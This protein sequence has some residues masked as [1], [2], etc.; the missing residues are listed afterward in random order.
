MMKMVRKKTDK[1]KKPETT[2]YIGRSLPSGL[3]PQYTVFK[4]GEIPKHL[5]ELVKNNAAIRGLIV[6]VSELQSARREAR[7]NGTLLNK[8]YKEV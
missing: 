7:K 2:I 6:P 4:G 8:F 5:T 3:L 1:Q